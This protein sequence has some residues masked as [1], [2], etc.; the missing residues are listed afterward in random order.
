MPPIP[1]GWAEFYIQE[2]DGFI[3]NID[4]YPIPNTLTY[5]YFDD[6]PN[7]VMHVTNSYEQF[8]SSFIGFALWD[9]PNFYWEVT[10]SNPIPENW[11]IISLREMPNI[12][13]N[14]NDCNIPDQI[15][16]VVIQNTLYE[17]NMYWV[18]SEGSP[19][20]S[21]CT[22]FETYGSWMHWDASSYFPNNTFGTIR[23]Y[24]NENIV[25]EVGEDAPINIIT[26][27]FRVYRCPNIAFSETLA[28][29]NSILRIYIENG[30]SQIEV[31]TI[32]EKLYDVFDSRTVVMIPL[33][34]LPMPVKWSLSG[35]MRN[36]RSRICI[37]RVTPAILSCKTPTP[38]KKWSHSV[39]LIL[40]YKPAVKRLQMPMRWLN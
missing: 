7:V 1:S 3:W 17:D 13:W 29:S 18:L 14:I 19:M 40:L 15:E 24:D 38:L 36:A 35:R 31:D 11:T 33:T 21:E 25:W 10:P 30:L 4:E 37:C 28:F 26:T 23:L 2:I 16:T 39:R 6:N 12:K 22:Y 32:L 8:P 20:P 5:F 34:I 27:D 9:I